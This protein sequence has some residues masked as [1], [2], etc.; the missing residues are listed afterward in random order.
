MTT[1]SRPTTAEVEAA[2]NTL[3]AIVTD[4]ASMMLHG[5][6]ADAIHTLEAAL[7]DRDALPVPDP[8]PAPDPATLAAGP[9]TAYMQGYLAGWEDYR[10][11][12][13]PPSG[14]E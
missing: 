5:V 11:V 14:E 7:A 13:G 4:D 1:G 3:T 2:L 8:I 10:A 9:V 12:M 6:G